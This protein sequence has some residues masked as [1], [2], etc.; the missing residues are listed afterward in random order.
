MNSIRLALL[1]AVF[2]AAVLA[3]IGTAHATSFSTSS[4]GCGWSGGSA[5]GSPTNYSWTSSAGWCS[6]AAGVQVDW[7]YNGNWTSDPW[8]WS[9]TLYA[10]GNAIGS[11]SSEHQI[12]VPAPMGGGY[13]QIEYSSY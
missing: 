5:G 3:G 11:L 13:G 10:Q 12:Y 7:Y 8:V 2:F 9:G 1:P 4:W 6:I